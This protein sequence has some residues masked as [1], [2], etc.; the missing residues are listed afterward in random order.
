MGEGEA[1][2]VAMMPAPDPMVVSLPPMVV[3][4]PMYD[5]LEVRPVLDALWTDIATRL[6]VAGIT[7]PTV[8]R[9]NSDY[10][11]A[12]LDPGLL[13]SQTCGYPFASTLRGR[14]QLV[15][16]PHY[17]VSGCNGPNYCS[18]IIARRGAAA[19]GQWPGGIAAVNS[20][21]SQ[22][23]FWALRAALAE[24]G[25][26]APSRLIETGSHRASLHAV[27]N[28]T[29]GIAAIDAVCWAMAAAHEAA[30]VVELDV[31]GQSPSAPGLPF[32]TSAATPPALLT[33]LRQALADA[34]AGPAGEV[35]R[36]SLFLSGLSVL[37]DAA[38]D[39][40]LAVQEIAKTI[41][42]P[43]QPAR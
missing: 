40:I 21:D 3:S 31:I 23:G 4:L 27:A 28:G 36:T 5:W 11:A 6:H 22:S 37:P 35:C 42:F 32:I 39:R 43:A 26:P 19:L 29:A 10:R 17:A 33:A 41:P 24:A 12:W 13:L 20:G 14:V 34:L 38:Y 18:M 8:L 15:A 25:C 7:A 16:T 2:A 1:E 9:H 30:T